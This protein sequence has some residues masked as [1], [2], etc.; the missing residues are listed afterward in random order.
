MFVSQNISDLESLIS[1]Y[2][3]HLKNVYGLEQYYGD[4]T[5]KLLISHT[6][7]LL[8]ILD[9]YED[10]TSLTV[11]LEQDEELEEEI[12]QEDEEQALLEQETP[13]YGENVFYA[14]SRTGD[15]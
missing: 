6:N 11:P 10:I 9:D 7:S 14:G 15:N 2:A 8:E 3:G 5:I 1:A 4:E 13:N 12:E